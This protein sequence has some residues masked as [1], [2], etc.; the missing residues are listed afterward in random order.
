VEHLQILQTVE[1]GMGERNQNGTLA[2]NTGKFTRSRSPPK[3]G[4]IVKRCLYKRQSLLG[5]N[6]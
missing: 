3:I 5:E 6:K 4:F 1:K 2:I